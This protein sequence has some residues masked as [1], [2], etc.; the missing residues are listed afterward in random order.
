MCKP[1]P[2]RHLFMIPE[3]TEQD[4]YPFMTTALD[5]LEGLVF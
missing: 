2:Y 5:S 4:R 1:V 3:G